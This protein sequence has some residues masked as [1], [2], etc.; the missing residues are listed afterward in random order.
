MTFIRAG[1]ADDRL[2]EIAASARQILNQ[3]CFSCHGAN[4]VARKNVFVL[5][6]NRLIASRTVVPGDS[7]SLLL[8]LVGSGAMPPG[9]PALT[10]GEQEILKDWIV[11]GA[12]R[13]DEPVDSGRSFQKEQSLLALIRNDLLQARERNRSFLRYFSLAHLYNAS[14]PDAELDT[15]RAALSKLVNSLSWHREV[16]PLTSI[17]PARTV[18]RVDLRDYNWTAATWNMLF[19]A[20]PYGVRGAES[21]AI[22]QLS[23]S[24]LPYVRADWFVANASVPPLYHDILGLPRTARE[25][26]QQL[27]IDA[28]RDLE[29]EKNVARAGLRSSGVSSNNRVLEPIPLRTAL[30]GRASI[31][32]AT[33]TI[34]TSS[35]TRF[36]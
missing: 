7:S 18:F 10:T 19:V 16:T 34:K 11:S 15:Y 31:S 27:G 21:R 4:G 17:D 12:P 30:I 2:R 1:S 23:G 24:T 25:L 22:D 8:S 35:R 14:V 33:W 26:E 29:E 6:R 13:W 28:A 5:D 3:R 36:D 9:G 20:Y 32:E